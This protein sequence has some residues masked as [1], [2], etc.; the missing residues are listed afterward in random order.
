[1]PLELAEGNLK[2]SWVG[3][4]EPGLKGGQGRWGWKRDLKGVG[5][6]PAQSAPA[7]PAVQEGIGG[8]VGLRVG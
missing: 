7:S 8:P 1:M 2:R 5:V 3:I 4:L 6:G